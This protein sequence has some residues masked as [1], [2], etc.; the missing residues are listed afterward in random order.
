M[1][2][3]V[4]QI[5][6]LK[7][8]FLSS[9]ELETNYSLDI[10][11]QDLIKIVEKA[12]S[13]SERLGNKFTIN[14]H[15]AE[16]QL[17]DSRLDKWCQ[18]VA[19]GNQ[20]KFVKRLAWDGLDLDTVRCALGSVNLA[21]Q[22][23]LPSWV[24][25]LKEG[26][27]AAALSVLQISDNQKHRLYID[28][29]KPLPFEDILVPFVDLARKKL[30]ECADTNCHLI[31]E[32]AYAQLERSLLVQLAGLC[33]SPLE[34]EFS[35]FR[36]LHNSALTLA[37]AQLQEDSYRLHYTEF[38]NSLLKDGLQSFFQEYSVLARLVATAVDF[39]VD[40]VAE[41]LSRLATDWN[42][43]QT[44]F[45]ENNELGQVVSVETALSDP[46]N[47]GRSVI[48]I[49]FASNKKLVYKPKNL[50]LEK[51]YYDFLA[52]INHHRI[53]LPFK[54]LKI[55]DCSTHG[56]MEFVEALPCENEEAV[57][58]FY[59]RAG[60]LLCIV[61]AL[62]GTDCHCENLIASGDQPV[63]VDLETLLHH[64]TWASKDDAKAH[65]I[66]NERLQDSVAGTALLPGWQ[67]VPYEQHEG[68]KIDLSG[69]GGYGEQEVPYRALKWKHINTDSMTVAYEEVKMLPK[70]NQPFG[71][72]IEIS[73]KNYTEELID[74]F[75]QMYQFLSQR[76]EV[77]LAADSPLTVF[78]RKKVR[79]V[80]RN[81]S[82]YFSILQKSLDHKYLRDGVEHSIELDVLSRAFLSSE[83]KHPF[84][85]ILTAEKQAIEQLDIPYFTAY[86]DSEAI[87]INSKQKIE[88]F[89][90]RPSYDDVIS[91]IR[92]L[93]DADLEQQISIIRGSLYSR[94]TKDELNLSSPGTLISTDIPVSLS[95]TEIL[96]QAIAIAR[97]IKEKAICGTDGSATWIS[98]GYLTEAQRFQLQ[99]M[100]YSL[101]DG[102][103][104]VAVFLAALAKVTGQ[105]KFSDLALASIQSVRKIIQNS[106]TELQQKLIEQMGI[107]G[108]KGI[109]S[110]VYAFVRIAD[111]LDEIQLIQEAQ[112]LAAWMRLDRVA[113]RQ[114]P[115]LL[116]GT[117]GIILSL[118]SLYKA[119]KKPMILNWAI[120]WGE[121][122]LNTRSI[123]NEG[124]ST[125]TTSDGKLLTGFSSGI[126]GIAYTLLQLYIFS[127][128][129]D[130]FS[131]AK[132]AISYEQSYLSSKEK[133]LDF[134]SAVLDK[135]IFSFL[136]SWSTSLPG[137]SIARI[138]C[139]EELNTQE[140]R[141]ELE[142][143]LQIICESKLQLIDNLC[144]GNFSQIE[145][146][147]L[148]SQQLS[149]SELLDIANK[150]AAQVLHR[151]SYTGYFQLLPN[152]TAEIHNP[153]FCQGTAGMGYEL[154]RLAYP[155]V[156]PSILLW[157]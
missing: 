84:W 60:M 153:S 132:E 76:K 79:L 33:V 131:A 30:I 80:L 20:Q 91:R 8:D 106:D 55:I 6:E 1:S 74:G 27:Q 28:S 57:K 151:A 127:R 19:K 43:I 129:S 134:E 141:Q 16:K 34:L 72:G 62:R 103:C 136:N 73:L 117:G 110:I 144:C 111:F 52:W 64:R 90:N 107:G 109:A 82:V 71:E 67:L 130:F 89:L 78:A 114:T 126:A 102:C 56:W 26:M 86:S 54:L 145:F 65:E 32:K 142:N 94:L 10:S 5:S 12:S 137:I 147:L 59:Q 83:K 31:S 50:G 47:C 154:L 140:I 21:E 24:E 25:T 85:G 2:S 23:D 38:V 99:P 61:Y 87:A 11:T 119:T 4:A 96:E 39:W 155:D 37:I 133:S 93:D 18:V 116:N 98:M 81:T 9:F 156:I 138:G 75:R 14:E 104:G 36:S 44:T 92:Q 88:E 143:S 22:Q 118:L 35:I 48:I 7:S 128:N 53:N 115:G 108:A 29:E 149:H 123:T 51:A 152:L 125:W 42:K 105:E 46:H 148:A 49:Q 135:D 70:Q 146:L 45:Q 122:L 101:Y 139:L 100:G 120:A 150:K 3:E 41:F 58:N 112:Q 13:L 66:A 17:I 68:L 124:F 77:L 121:H 69:F 97:E 157:Q 40:T 15:R 95:Q 113:V 63:L